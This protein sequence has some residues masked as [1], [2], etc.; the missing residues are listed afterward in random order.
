ML[1]YWIFRFFYRIFTIEKERI[2]WRDGLTHPFFPCCFSC[3]MS[4]VPEMSD[5][6]LEATLNTL[7]KYPL[8]CYPPQL[9]PVFPPSLSWGCWTVTSLPPLFSQ[10]RSWQWAHLGVHVARSGFLK[11]NC[12]RRN[13]LHVVWLKEECGGGRFFGFFCLLFVSAAG[14]N[15]DSSDV[16][17]L[18]FIKTSFCRA[19]TDGRHHKLLTGL[20][21]S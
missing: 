4:R 9:L 15:T 5:N 13:E 21:V 6:S 2:W 17:H 8:F 12:G 19:L 20:A 1:L 14:H 7:S 18:N 10:A 16:L 3:L 11:T